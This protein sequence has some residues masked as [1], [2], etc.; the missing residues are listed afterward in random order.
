M[1]SITRRT[2]L[3]GG[4]ATAMAA[5]AALAVDQASAT[6]AEVSEHT[7]AVCKTLTVA[8]AKTRLAVME[9]K[10]HDA[11][12]ESAA[13]RLEGEKKFSEGQLAW[14]EVISLRTMLKYGV[15]VRS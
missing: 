12:W 1:K 15:G 8:E 10:Y 2:A 4:A 7:G 3:K 6:V 9:K 11:K 13:L 5:T 14:C